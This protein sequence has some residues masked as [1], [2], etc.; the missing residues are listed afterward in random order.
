M[1]TKN[2]LLKKVAVSWLEHFNYCRFL[3]P[4]TLT[5]SF[6]RP[7]NPVLRFLNFQKCEYCFLFTVSYIPILSVADFSQ[8]NIFS[9]AKLN[10]LL[11]FV[12]SQLWAAHWS[13][14]GLLYPLWEISIWDIRRSVKKIFSSRWEC[15]W[16]Y[17]FG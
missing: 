3:F 15:H 4:W 5:N 6:L 17:E 1:S 11:F 2:N 16:I 12:R 7:K 14:T 8:T 9:K 13:C 10:C